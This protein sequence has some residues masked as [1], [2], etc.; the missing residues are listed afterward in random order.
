MIQWLPSVRSPHCHWPHPRLWS[1]SN[2]MMTPTLTKLHTH[3]IGQNLLLPWQH[4]QL[5]SLSL[6]WIWLLSLQNFV[7]WQMWL[8][9]FATD[10]LMTLHLLWCQYPLP[11]P[12]IHMLQFSSLLCPWRKLCRWCTMMAVLS[13]LS[14]LVIRQMNLIARCTGWQRR[15]TVQWVAGNSDI[16]GTSYSSAMEFN[17]LME[18]NSLL[19]LAPL[20]LFPRQNEASH[21][22]APGTNT[23]MR[24]TWILGLGIAFWLAGFVIPSFLLTGQHARTLIPVDRGTRY[25]WMFGLKTHSSD[26][27][28]AKIRLFCT[29]AGSCLLLLL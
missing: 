25:N 8:H 7:L 21:W 20:L 23:L 4:L 28:L 6:T 10:G 24:F 16:T 13:R 11:L 3:P 26:S 12:P 9:P 27:I 17:V 2:R 19:L 15:F 18:V 5:K 14:A 22:I 29:A 1:Q